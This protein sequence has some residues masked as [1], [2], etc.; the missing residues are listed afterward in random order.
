MGDGREIMKHDELNQTKFLSKS[1]S[2]TLTKPR[3]HDTV[4]Q[5][6]SQV[7]MRI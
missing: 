6:V 7:V 1:G 4:A 2:V 5:V 3:P